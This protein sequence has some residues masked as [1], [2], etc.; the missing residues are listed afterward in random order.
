[1]ISLRWLIAAVLMGPSGLAGV[2]AACLPPPYFVAVDATARVKGLEDVPGFRHVSV[3]RPLFTVSNLRCLAKTFRDEPIS[4]IGLFVYIFD[5]R[6]AAADFQGGDVMTMTRAIAQSDR[7]LRAR[8]VIDPNTREQSLTL[9]PLGQ[10]RGDEFESRIDI[11]D[12]G[13]PSCRFALSSRCLLVF[14]IIEPP[15]AAPAG[16]RI[17]VTL[18]A[19]RAR[20]GDVSNVRILS[21]RGGSTRER[22]RWTSAAVKNLKTW[23][24]EPSPH[25]DRLRVTYE[26]GAG[27]P[28]AVASGEL[29]VQLAGDALV[30]ARATR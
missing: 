5:T 4:K 2:A 26:V 23:W 9:M 8:F 20:S 13:S 19:S 11:A 30:T 10:Q 17:S 3:A 1:M 7:M 6:W 21:A 27:P 29:H 18:Q 22:T 24:F 25:A 28:R 12:D 15:A 16:A 14:D